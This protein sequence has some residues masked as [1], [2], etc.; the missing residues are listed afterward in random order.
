VIEQSTLDTLRERYEMDALGWAGVIRY[1][2]IMGGL[3]SFFGIMGMMA[4]M[5]GSEGVAA[6]MTILAGGAMTWW[7]I[8]LASDLRERYATSSKIVL[9]LG[10]TLWSTG[11]EFLAHAMGADDKALVAL[12]GLCLPIMGFLAYRF[13]NSLLL[14]MAVT[15]LFHW[16]GA[17][18]Q[19]VGRSTYEFDIQDPHLMIPAALAAFAVG[20]Y[21]ERR[22]VER[23]GRFYKVW[24]SMG[25]LY[26]NMS[27]LI[28]TIWPHETAGAPVWVA[29]FTLATIGQILLGARLHNGLVR[30]F[31]VVFFA[32][33]I[34]TR[35]HEEYW[36]KLELG[37]YLLCGG[38][39]LFAV[40]VCLE[41]VARMTQPKG[42]E[43]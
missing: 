1:L 36:D 3:I 2:G 7:G 9:S 21:H 16:V 32:I 23:T 22:L 34:F 42:G 24:E 35:Y 27:L 20:L 10:V 17:W 11:V 29:L 15:S 6:S 37:T 12:A 13:H 8:H 19:M 28:L 39:V 31:G 26:F 4:A 43:A 38:L 41:V 25:L 40:G 33:D 30:G 18:N 14:L 5:S